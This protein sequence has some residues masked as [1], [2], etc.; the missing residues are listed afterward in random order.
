MKHYIILSIFFILF[1]CNEKKKD[2]LITKYDKFDYNNGTNPWINAYKDHVFFAC[3]QEAYKD[4]SLWHTIEKK[5]LLNP[6]DGFI[7][8][9]KPARVLG[10][11][12]ADSI[13]SYPPF[14]DMCLPGQ[15]YY[16]ADCLHYYNSKELDSMAR[17]AYADYLKIVGE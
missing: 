14:C 5:D 1:S 17:K 6:Y 8:F 16:M 10:K 2:I 3:L 11:K 12:I 7:G 15:N 13:P 9:E 4:D